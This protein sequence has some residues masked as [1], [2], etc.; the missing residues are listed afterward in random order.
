MFDKV[1]IAW[2]GQH[3]GEEPPLVGTKEQ[4]AGGIF[5]SGCNLLCAFC[6][7]YVISQQGMGRFYSIEELADIMLDLQA[8][9]AIN[10]DLVTPTIWYKQIKEAINLAKENGLSVPIVW[11]SNAYEK[12]EII[13]EMKGLVDVYLPDY[14]YSDDVLAKKYS[15]ATGYSSLA[16]DAIKEMR[17]QVGDLICDG[18]G[19]AQRGLIVRHMILPNNVENSLG[20]LKKLAGI[21]NSIHIS[22]MN[23]YY[24]MHNASEFPE[25]TR[26][27]STQEFE[28]VYQKLIDLGFENG[29]VQDKDSAKFLIPD[30]TKIDP[31]EV[32][33]N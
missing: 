16:L 10:I 6:Q 24:P 12:V 5:F 23:Q 25:L 14:K 17:E 32:V 31:F 8:E 11:N 29:W 19:N 7:N 15:K 20:V 2:H 22:L 18:Q 21:S 28:I 3:F 26:E 33:D 9:G 1:K 4:G 30:F 13:K 27:V